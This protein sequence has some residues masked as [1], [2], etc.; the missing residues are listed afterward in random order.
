LNSTAVIKVELLLQRLLKKN[1][2]TLCDS[3]VFNRN[4]LLTGRAN[5]LSADEIDKAAPV[6]QAI[7]AV[8]LIIEKWL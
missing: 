1:L 5:W 8:M 6:F 2:F 7:L 3:P 4:P